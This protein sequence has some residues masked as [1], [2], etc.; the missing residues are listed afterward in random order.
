MSVSELCL[1]TMTF[2]EQVDQV[3]AHEILDCAF[4]QGINFID[5][6]EMYPVPAKPDTYGIAECIIGDWLIKNKSKRQ[7]IVCATKIS[8]PAR[9]LNWIRGGNSKI[10]SL[11]IES[12]CDESLRR[13][14][15]DVIDLYQIHWPFRHV[16]S[17]GNIY[18]DPCKCEMDSMSIHEQLAALSNLIKKGK[19]RSIGLSNETPYGVHEFV[20]LADQF[21]LPRIVSVQNSYSLLNRSVENALDETLH[22][23]GVSLLAYSPLAFG[24][25]TGKYDEMGLDCGDVPKPG[26][27]AK[28]DSMRKQRWGRP[29]ALEAARIYNK[30]AQEINLTPSQLALAYCAG[31]WQIASTIIGVTNL[32]QLTENLKCTNFKLP[33]HIEELIDKI[34]SQYW[35]PVN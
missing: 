8:G 9:G 34:R 2:G 35:D 13:L 27:L 7:S 16:P 32:D 12:A 30:L 15:T 19:V 14:K 24:L 33:L 17:F 25:L 23:L 11:Q 21:N 5:T 4:D 29:K 28:Y 1:G 26:R 20:K 31:K 3:H 22:H 6:A 18:F 10:S